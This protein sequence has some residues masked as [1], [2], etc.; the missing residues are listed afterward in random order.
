MKKTILALMII[1]LLSKFLGFARELVLAYFYGASAVSDAYLISITIPTVI[2]AFI[3]TGLATSYIP[4]YTE[5]TAQKGVKE[6]DRFSNNLINFLII[7]CT[8]VIFAGLVFAEPVVKLF[9]FGF[10]GDT[11]RLAVDFTR[12]SILGI[13]FMAL[14]YVFISYLQIK[15]NFIIPALIGFP[16]NFFIITSFFLSADGSYIFL[17]WGLVLAIASQFFLLLPFAF[18]NGY[19]YRLLIDRKDPYLRRVIYLALPVILGSSISQINTLVD[20]TLAS[21][22]AVGGISALNY[23]NRLNGF[24]QGIFVLTVATV[25][26][27]AISRMAADN[28]IEGLKKSIAQAVNT[29]NLMLIPVTVGA[30][31]LTEP[32]VRL[33][34]GRGAFD[35]RAVEMT[36]YALFF[37]AIGMTGFGLREILARAFY[38]LQDTKTPMINAAV[39]FTMNIILNLILSRYLGIGGLALA[40]SIAAVFTAGLLMFNLRKKIGALGG[41]N[42]LLTFI[43]ISAASAIMGA[44][45]FALYNTLPLYINANLALVTSIA[46]GAVVYFIIVS[47]MK[48][49]EVDVLLRAAR[50]RIAQI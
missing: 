28:N 46:L 14:A 49:E 37:Y 13:Y 22:I 21:G 11:L 42:I 36:A 50:A 5:I 33:L 39:G 31:L 7:F 41:K 30:M 9:A 24:V 48:I 45:V 27:P 2:F 17:P 29:V 15:N 3:G 12:I 44:A 34:F 40:T 25:I 4:L 8:L 23:A 32:I 35:A 47:F 43:K 38:S 16:Y 6:A 10:K 20:R 26:Y 1:T 19:R 18:K